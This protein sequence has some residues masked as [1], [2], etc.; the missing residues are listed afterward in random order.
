MRRAAKLA[1]LAIFGVMLGAELLAPFPYDRQ[2]RDEVRA[3]PSGRHLLGTDAIGRDRFA[4][5]LYGGRISLVLAPAA[6]LV[7][8][9]LA[10]AV[11][12]TAVLA[13]GV[14]ERAAMIA[15][16][17]VLALPWIFLLLAVRAILPL[18]TSPEVSA[19]VIFALLGSLGWAAPARILTAAVASELRSDYVLAARAAGCGASRLALVHVIPNLAPIACAQF[20]VT[21]PVF[22]LSESNLSLLG[23]G[24][25]EPMPSWGNLLRDLQNL[26]S[27]AHQPWVAAPLVLL[28]VTLSCCHVAQPSVEDVR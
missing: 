14:W 5:L 16:D 10:L 4:R 28:I 6:A 9:G 12:V 3:A 7:S 19:G 13:G 24:I 1:L 27:L 23:L 22:L 26:P 17:L 18:N 20:W 11:A 15:I 8:V 25:A 2:F 21:A